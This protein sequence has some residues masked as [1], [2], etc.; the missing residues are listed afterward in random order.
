MYT[1]YRISLA[2]DLRQQRGAVS[3]IVYADGLLKIT[4]GLPHL[5]RR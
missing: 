5:G 4:I 2:N 1:F 3:I